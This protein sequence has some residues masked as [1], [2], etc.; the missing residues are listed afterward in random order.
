MKGDRESI[1]DNKRSGL[2]FVGKRAVRQTRTAA[3]VDDVTYSHCSQL[4]PTPKVVPPSLLPVSSLPSG[5]VY[6]W[7]GNYPL[8]RSSPSRLFFTPFVLP[9]RLNHQP[10]CFYE[11]PPYDG[12][13]FHPPLFLP[14]PSR[15]NHHCH[16]LTLWPF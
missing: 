2:P 15:S 11:S 5:F 9:P 16:V 14:S 1:G 3:V 12:S 6:P 7:S 4:L 8:A 13:H 10:P